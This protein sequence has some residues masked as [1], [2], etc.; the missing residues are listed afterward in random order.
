MADKDAE[1]VESSFVHVEEEEKPNLG[2]DEQLSVTMLTLDEGPIK[3]F[4]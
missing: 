4:M 1:Q 2:D 3:V